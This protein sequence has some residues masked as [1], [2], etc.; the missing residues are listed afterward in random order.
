[1]VERVNPGVYGFSSI[2]STAKEILT[3]GFLNGVAA[4][5]SHIDYWICYGLARNG[6]LVFPQHHIKKK[7]KTK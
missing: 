1:M 5:G 3:L 2:G 7:K 6:C 4:S